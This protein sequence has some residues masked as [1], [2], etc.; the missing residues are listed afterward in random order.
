MLCSKRNRESELLLKI[1]K[2]LADAGFF[3]TFILGSFGKDVDAET[4]YLLIQEGQDGL[5]RV[6]NWGEEKK[7]DK[8]EILIYNIII[9]KVKESTVDAFIQGWGINSYNLIK[10]R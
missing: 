3:Y 5:D 4:S 7:V 8:R 9:N 6:E 1:G 10:K 2:E